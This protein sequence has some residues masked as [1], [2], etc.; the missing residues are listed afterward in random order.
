L[1]R[2]LST[3]SVHTYYEYAFAGDLS[4]MINTDTLTS[5]SATIGGGFFGGLLIGYA[6]KKVIKMLAVVI[7][8]FLAGLAFLQYQQIATIHW[9]KVEGAITKLGTLTSSTINDNSNVAALAMMSNFGIP[10]TSS[11]S[12]GFTIGFMK[13]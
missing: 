6:L 1:V 13:G 12:I 5:M 8:L 2:I 9:H 11:M 7:G 3:Y 10:L 4:M